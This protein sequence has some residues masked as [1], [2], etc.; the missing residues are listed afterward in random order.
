MK[1]FKFQIIFALLF[2]SI[3]FGETVKLEGYPGQG[4][5]VDTLRY[6][7]LKI[8]DWDF[9]KDGEQRAVK[10]LENADGTELTYKL[11]LQ[12]NQAPLV[13]IIPGLGGHYAGIASTALAEIIFDKGFSI[14][15]ISDPFCW[16][17]LL[18]ASSK[19]TPGFTPTD[20]RDA[21]N[22]LDIILNDAEKEYGTNIFSEKILLGYSLGA[23]DTLF[24]AD[25]DSK[26]Q[27]IN[28][29]RFVA[30]SPP[31]NLLYGLN[32][33]DDFY[34]IWRTWPD[35]EIEQ[36]KNKAVYLIENPPQAGTNNLPITSQEAQFAIGFVF[37]TQLGETIKAI[38]SRKDFGI[39]KIPYKSFSRR[40]LEKEI[41]S[42]S[43]EDYM[44]TFLKSS[45]S[46]LFGRGFS[47]YD[48]GKQASLPAIEK[49][50][51]SNP[52]IRVIHTVNDFLLTDLDREWLENIMGDR[53]LF[54]NHGGHLGYF[55]HPTAQDYIIS[56]IEGKEFNENDLSITN[57]IDKINFV[58]SAELGN[59]GS[60]LKSNTSNTNAVNSTGF[61]KSQHN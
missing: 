41:E 47:I 42:M 12:T 5:Y 56:A 60:V 3:I 50:L 51:L 17:F 39:L 30:L 13:V 53:L 55:G 16:E 18:N 15:I 22:A 52:N 2:S 35:D 21:Y 23:L 27:K 37:R 34:D 28:F 43:Y 36:I 25:I 4:S 14:L 40:K 58:E 19:L 61:V 8:K 33:L 38:H 24:I 9:Y 20:A 6:V 44:N 10:V 54:F 32:Q 45:H 59:S 26:E 1:N 48:L 7:Y 46:N 29:N 57:S 49:T 31:V 11:W